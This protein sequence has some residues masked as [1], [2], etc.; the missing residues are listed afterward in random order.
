[1]TTSDAAW[2]P[3]PT[4]RHQ[5]RYWDGA[6]WTAW[7]ADDGVQGEDPLPG[8]G[9]LAAA[10]S[11]AGGAPSGDL[12]G[13]LESVLR[14]TNL[15]VEMLGGRAPAGWRW[16]RDATGHDVARL[17]CEG[18][19]SR[20]CDL[21]GAAVL[22]VTAGIHGKGHERRVT[23]LD[24]STAAGTLAKVSHTQA[25]L[26]KLKCKHGGDHVLTVQLKQTMTGKSA[27][28]VLLDVDDRQVG[29]IE[30]TDRQARGSMFDAR[31][32]LAR[33]PQLTDPVRALAVAAPILLDAYL[34]APMRG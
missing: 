2:H 14:H 27:D 31:L 15:D 17:W 34:N 23:G 6:V 13:D 7:V 32:L 1:M 19:T 12:T 18:T 33:D 29:T 16:V 26:T 22:T 24:V 10:A 9:A 8:G 5:L 11:G 30:E 3:D 20:L 28:I 4:G 25:R 21:G